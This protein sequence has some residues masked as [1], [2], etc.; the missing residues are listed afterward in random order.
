ML[1]FNGTPK[2]LAV[3]FFKKV[4]QG[5]KKHYI[6]IRL[7]LMHY[8]SIK[9]LSHCFHKKNIASL[10]LNNKYI[11]IKINA[12]YLAKLLQN[13]IMHGSIK[14]CILVQQKILH[15][16]L[17][18]TLLH[19]LDENT[20]SIVNKKRFIVF[21]QTIKLTTSSSNKNTTSSL[22]KNTTSGF[23]KIQVHNR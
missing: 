12:S 20:T 5:L 9:T 16:L 11:N 13:Y 14:H 7:K 8:I 10:Y 23:Y 19:S 21:D 17:I 4:H 22:D 15:H 18:K 6:V 2:F 3:M 1:Y